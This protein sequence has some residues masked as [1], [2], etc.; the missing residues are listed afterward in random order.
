M[1]ARAAVISRLD[2]HRSAAKLTH[3][4]V[5]RL[6]LSLAVGPRHQLLDMWASLQGYSQHG[7][8][9]LPNIRAL[10]ERDLE[11]HMPKR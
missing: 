8:L 9:F 7:S 11:G 2:W 4:A 3:L 10:R 1:L 6:R 5:G